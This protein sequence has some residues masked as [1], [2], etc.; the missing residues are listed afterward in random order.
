MM[1][2]LRIIKKKLFENIQ[3]KVC[4]KHQ[5]AKLGGGGKKKPGGEARG[6][7]NIEVYNLFI[8]FHVPKY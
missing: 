4:C 5:M 1:D 7:A 2:D 6:V 8:P 3:T